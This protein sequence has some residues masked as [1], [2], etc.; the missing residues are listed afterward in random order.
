M[1]C[2]REP[3]TVNHRAVVVADVADGYQ[4]RFWRERGDQVVRG[5]K[6]I[7]RTNDLQADAF[8]V[9][10][11]LPGGVLQ[12]EFA[13]GSDD[14]IAAMPLNAVSDGDRAGAGSGCD[15]DVFGFRAD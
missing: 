4:P 6:A 5:K 13:F 1:A 12:R 2:L 8:A 3:G 15:S 7:L 10:H 14:L 9:D 11:R